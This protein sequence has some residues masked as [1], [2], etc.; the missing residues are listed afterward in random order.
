MPYIPQ[1]RREAF[2][3]PIFDVAEQVETSEELS[4]VLFKTA[5]VVAT[6]SDGDYAALNAIYGA[7]TLAAD[8]FKRRLIHPY[9]AD[10]RHQNGDVFDAAA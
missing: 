10:A 5:C 7:M 1:E 2:D 9:A 4:Y 6:N 8:E 3:E